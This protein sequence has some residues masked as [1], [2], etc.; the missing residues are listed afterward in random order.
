M[1]NSP[2]LLFVCNP[3]KHP[4]IYLTDIVCRPSGKESTELQITQRKGKL[5]RKMK[6]MEERLT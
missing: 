5:Y 3:M 4:L 1:D 2:S 6:E